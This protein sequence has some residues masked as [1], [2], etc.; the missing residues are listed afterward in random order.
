[1]RY[2]GEMLFFEMENKNTDK[3]IEQKNKKIGI[4]LFFV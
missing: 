1:M 4:E 3:K 2:E